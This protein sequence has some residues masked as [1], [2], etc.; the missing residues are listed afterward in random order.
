M[1]LVSYVIW[2]PAANM[3]GMCVIGPDPNRFSGYGKEMECYLALK[4][5]KAFGIV[6]GIPMILGILIIVTGFL[7]RSTFTFRKEVKQPT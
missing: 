7:D 3:L 1:T 6:V 5:M 4:Q 2:M